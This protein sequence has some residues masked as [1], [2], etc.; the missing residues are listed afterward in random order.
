MNLSR[1]ILSTFIVTNRLVNSQ[2]NT[3]IEQCSL[4]A[5]TCI[6]DE[7]SETL[8]DREA[9]RALFPNDCNDKS[10]AV[11]ESRIDLSIEHKEI[12]DEIIAKSHNDSLNIMINVDSQQTFT[13][14][15][16][17][18]TVDL[19]KSGKISERLSKGNLDVIQSI[20]PDIIIV[21]GDD[22]PN[23][24]LTFS[25]NFFFWDKTGRILTPNQDGE[26]VGI[27]LNEDLAF[28]ATKNSDQSIN[29]PDNWGNDLNYFPLFTFGFHPISITDDMLTGIKDT[30]GS[31][32]PASQIKQTLKSI[33]LI[34]NNDY[35]NIDFQINGEF[36]KDQLIP[37]KDQLFKKYLVKMINKNS[38]IKARIAQFLSFNSNKQKYSI[39]SVDMILS[40]LTEKFWPAHGEVGVDA[41]ITEPVA[42]AICSHNIPIIAVNKGLGS[43]AY[44]AVKKTNGERSSALPLIIDYFKRQ[45]VDKEINLHV[46]GVAYEICAATTAFQLRERYSDLSITFHSE[47]S[48]AL[49]STKIASINEGFTEL[50]INISKGDTI[51]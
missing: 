16:G 27:T 42:E 32:I 28:G 37:S 1:I 45:A 12:L 30:N 18:L 33:G 24:S 5:N 41:A 9:L 51:K 50:G 44:G 4:E 15:D 25:K 34:S 19:T 23:S 35:I 13:E 26:K 20:K 7:Q 8:V 46:G 14:K 40:K 2:I 48:A 36:L 43:E 47:M 21:T 10:I 17:R 22:H 49:N 6:Y 39:K 3:K 29:I 11:D 38:G 31:I